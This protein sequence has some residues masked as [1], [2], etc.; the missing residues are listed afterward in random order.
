MV[1]IFALE[2][3]RYGVAQVRLIV[4]PDTCLECIVP[5][6]ILESVLLIALQKEDTSISCVAVVDPRLAETS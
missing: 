5:K 2:D 3:V 1:R 4:G 6:Q